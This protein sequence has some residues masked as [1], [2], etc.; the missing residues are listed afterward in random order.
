MQ[1]ALEWGRIN[2]NR[3]CEELGP[4]PI[5]LQCYGAL[6]SLS[7]QSALL[8]EKCIPSL[9]LEA[10]NEDSAPTRSKFSM[11]KSSCHIVAAYPLHTSTSKK[12]SPDHP[13][14][15]S[16]LWKVLKESERN[17]KERELRCSLR[18]YW[19]NFHA[20]RPVTVGGF[21]IARDIRKICF[22]KIGKHG[23]Q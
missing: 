19:T 17:K 16:G 22:P 23:F 7:V 15:S 13:E 20:T 12:P 2:W 8:L 3:G 21:P 4:F 1:N 9:T 14:V 5:L 6:F 11:E 10:L 18:T